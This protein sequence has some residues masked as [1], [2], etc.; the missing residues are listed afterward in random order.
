MAEHKKGGYA[1]IYLDKRQTS[2]VL[3]CLLLS[4]AMIIIVPLLTVRFEPLSGFL[5]VFAIYWICFCIPI[6]LYFGKGSI[7]VSVSLSAMPIWVPLLALA[8]PGL[9]FLGAG[10]FGWLG[11]ENGILAIAVICALINGPLEELA[12][13]RTFRVNSDG[14]LYFELLGLFLFT[15][16]HVPLYFANDV[17]FD[18]GASG[19]IG[20]AFILGAVWLF[21]TR[22]SNSVGWSMVSHALVN[23]AGFI[24]LFA[25]N[26][27]L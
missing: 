20:G 27:G 9:V 16:W 17:S 4:L 11:S 1:L 8:L 19:L 2:L 6:A 26:F 25:L 5:C 22:F 23:T 10:T 15:L 24:P 18:H 12:W 21:I 13:R 3:L 14:L 7:G